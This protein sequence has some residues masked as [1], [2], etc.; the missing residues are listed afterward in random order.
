MGPALQMLVGGAMLALVAGVRGEHIPS[1]VSA[2][3]WLAVAYLAVLGSLVG[4]TAYSWLLRHARPAV[5]TSYAYVNP[6]I[7]V[8]IGAALYG[9]PIGVSTLVANV[10]IG[11]AV[12]LALRK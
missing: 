1:G 12:M 2:N 3:A 6:V 5:A 9:E 8:V 11:G 10:L 7:A 4:F